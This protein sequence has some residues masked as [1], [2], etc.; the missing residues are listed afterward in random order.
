MKENLLLTFSNLIFTEGLTYNFH[1]I[2]VLSSQNEQLLPSRHFTPHTLKYSINYKKK[3]SIITFRSILMIYYFD[4]LDWWILT[5]P[6]PTSSTAIVISNCFCHIVH[7]LG[8]C[9]ED[10]WHTWADIK[11]PNNTIKCASEPFLELIKPWLQRNFMQ[12]FGF[13]IPNSK[14]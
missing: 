12:N 5:V 1:L 10:L 11:Q 3:H 2:Q 9:S 8:N 7:F 6:L 4:I 13:E 14:N